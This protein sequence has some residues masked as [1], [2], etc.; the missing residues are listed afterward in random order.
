MPYPKMVPQRFSADNPNDVFFPVEPPYIEANVKHAGEAD[1]GVRV[2]RSSPEA[3]ELQIRSHGPVNGKRGRHAGVDTPVYSRVSLN[4]QGL[5][6]LIL[7]LQA[8]RDG[9]PLLTD[10]GPHPFVRSTGDASICSTC[11]G[12]PSDRAL[13]PSGR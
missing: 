5:N 8:A 9:L 12:Y 1:S 2:L 4:R 6:G 10:P 7:A 11:G 13:H 3:I